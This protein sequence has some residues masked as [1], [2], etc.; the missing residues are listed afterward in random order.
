[1]VIVNPPEQ[2]FN[3]PDLE[4]ATAV[5][6]ELKN[7][8][9]EVQRVDRIEVPVIVKELEI[10]EIQVPVIV[11]EIEYREIQVPVIH[12]EIEIVRVEVPVLV[13]QVEIQTLEKPVIIKEIE[14]KDVPNWVKIA[15]VAQFITSIIML[16]K[17]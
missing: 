15:L 6:T 7:N 16:L 9:K 5:S 2:W 3:T 8:S 14:Y 11:K 13:K 4:V 17:K 12:R 10:R 1:M